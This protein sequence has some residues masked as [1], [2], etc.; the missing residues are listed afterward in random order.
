MGTVMGKENETE[1]GWDMDMVKAGTEI[2]YSIHAH[3]LILFLF[4]ATT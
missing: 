2:N 3:V 1:R 4:S